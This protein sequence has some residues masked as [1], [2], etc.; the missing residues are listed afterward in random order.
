LGPKLTPL[1]EYSALSGIEDRAGRGRGG[2]AEEGGIEEGGSSRI[3]DFSFR[4]SEWGAVWMLFRILISASSA[5]SLVLS[6]RG[7]ERK[8]GIKN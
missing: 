2:S 5:S 6:P 3:L 1:E 7:E 8:K 4:S